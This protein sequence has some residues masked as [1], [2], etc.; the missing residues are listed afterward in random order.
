MNTVNFWGHTDADMLEVG[1]PGL[2]LPEARS[3]FAFWAAMK[4]PLIV[5]ADLTSVGPEY[6]AILRNG[7]LVAFHQDDVHGAA[8]APY[9][10]GHLPDWT[11]N[12]TYPAQYWSG[13]SQQGT[14]VLM[15]NTLSEAREMTVDFAEVPQLEAGATYHI[16]DAWTGDCCGS[17]TGR[18]TFTVAAHDT[19][20]LVFQYCGKTLSKKADS[21]ESSLL[22][23][24]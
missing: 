16:L 1:V 24:D 8:A 9:K 15:L 17:F 10:W 6:V 22:L 12:D 18:A 11:W 3:H 7:P 14:V 2:S 19:A 20:V 23:L 13:A 4:S 5:G 21:D